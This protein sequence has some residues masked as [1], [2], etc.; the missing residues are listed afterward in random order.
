MKVVRAGDDIFFTKTMAE[1]LEKQ[2]FFEDAL[3]I[4]KI[5]F[6]TNPGN[7]LLKDKIADLKSLA[8]R[9]RSKRMNKD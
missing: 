7:D 6:D 9:S 5:L 8:E 4:Y 1:V 3:T 2:G